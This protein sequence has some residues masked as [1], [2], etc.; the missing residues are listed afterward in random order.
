M[1]LNQL[2]GKQRAMYLVLQTLYRWQNKVDVMVSLEDGA[3]VEAL[4]AQEQAND[5]GE[6]QD[7]RNEAREMGINTDLPT[8]PVR[9]FEVKTVAASI[10]PE[11][12]VG[13]YYLHGAGKH[14]EP[15]LYDWV[16]DAFIVTATSQEVL[17]VQHTFS[18]PEPV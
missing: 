18:L 3:A 16:S 4:Y 7:A 5:T 14:S 2:T 1:D 13:W 17:V 10:Y 12:W 8:P 11:I 15:T 9:N 6:F